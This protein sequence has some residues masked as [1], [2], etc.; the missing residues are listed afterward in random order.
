MNENYQLRVKIND[1]TCSSQIEW[2]DLWTDISPDT[3][4]VPAYILQYGFKYLYTVGRYRF[5][6]PHQ[7]LSILFDVNPVPKESILKGDKLLQL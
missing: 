4:N 6:P 3:L 5:I 7:I 1:P 2:L